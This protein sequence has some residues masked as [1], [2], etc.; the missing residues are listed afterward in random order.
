MPSSFIALNPHNLV[1]D[2]KR[3]LATPYNQMHPSNN[4]QLEEH[5][6]PYIFVAIVYLPFASF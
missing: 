3:L 2:Q 1:T 5:L 6:G 4:S